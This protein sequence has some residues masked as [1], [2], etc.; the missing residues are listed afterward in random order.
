MDANG[1]MKMKKKPTI[2]ERIRDYFQA[3]PK[4]VEILDGDYTSIL[5]K[6][7]WKDNTTQRGVFY[8]KEWA[9]NPTEFDD[10]ELEAER[11]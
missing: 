1:V 4:K 9:L 6:V 5:F 10:L 7:T 8:P 11:I 2:E 3:K